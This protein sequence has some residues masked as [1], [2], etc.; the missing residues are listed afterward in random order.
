MLQEALNQK[1][2]GASE[3]ERKLSPYWLCNKS[4]VKCAIFLKP[5]LSQHGSIALVIHRYVLLTSLPQFQTKGPFMTPVLYKLRELIYFVFFV[6]KFP[7][8]SGSSYEIKRFML[9]CQILLSRKVNTV[10]HYQLTNDSYIDSW[11][12]AKKQ[13]DIMKYKLQVAGKCS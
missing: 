9:T 4:N 5:K 1:N 7:Y 6:R 11:H 12:A 10:S 8:N 2:E 3:Q 13:P